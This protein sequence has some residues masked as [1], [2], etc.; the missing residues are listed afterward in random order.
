MSDAYE[1]ARDIGSVH[2]DAMPDLWVP[3]LVLNRLIEAARIVVYTTGPAGPRGYGS[4]LPRELIESM[5]ID[6]VPDYADDGYAL[7]WWL[8]TSAREAPRQRRQF[9]ARKITMA[10]DAMRW[11]VI[12]LPVQDG[13]RRVIHLY[14]RCKVYR[15][16]FDEACRRKAWSRATAYRARDRALGL[17]AQGLNRDGVPIK[18]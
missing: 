10:E 3:K 11:P 9:S 15:R 5:S 13:P 14:L 17:I 6:P 7:P 16:P 1:S 8:Q 4:S 12:Y 2:C 18:L